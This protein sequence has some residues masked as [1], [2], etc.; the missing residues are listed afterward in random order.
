MSAVA[1]R[2]LFEEGT[3]EEVASAAS[4][5]Y[6]R[7]IQAMTTPKNTLAA[8]DLFWREVSY[9]TLRTGA[10]RK[11]SLGQPTDS[12]SAPPLNLYNAFCMA[13]AL[14]ATL[15]QRAESKEGAYITKDDLRSVMKWYG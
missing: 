10:M 14:P 9:Q 2:R 8:L 13:Q 6:S 3:R 1:A 4:S 5:D 15:R 7:C 11:H 12:C